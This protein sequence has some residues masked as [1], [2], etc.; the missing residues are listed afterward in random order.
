MMPPR[1]MSCLFLLGLYHSFM[2]HVGLPALYA[3]GG[4]RVCV[5]WEALG[6]HLFP[7]FVCIL[8]KAVAAFL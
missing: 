4:G 8:A 3:D 1:I 6:N 7:S 2:S 5:R